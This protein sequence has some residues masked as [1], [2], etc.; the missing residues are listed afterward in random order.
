MKWRI[1]AVIL[2]LSLLGAW[3]GAATAGV[4]GYSLDRAGQKGF[5]ESSSRGA[6]RR[7]GRG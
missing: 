2:A 1:M 7:S 4:L 3:T 5:T 6:Q